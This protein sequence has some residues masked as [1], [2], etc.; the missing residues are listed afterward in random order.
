MAKD[1]WIQRAERNGGEEGAAFDGDS[2]RTVLFGR[3]AHQLR[4]DV[5]EHGKLRVVDGEPDVVICYGGDGT[6]LAA[7]I[8]WP[9]IP[10]VPILNSRRGHRC[11]PHPADEVIARL[12]E[13]SLVRNEYLKLCGRIYRQDAKT[14]ELSL[15]ALN[16][17]N[18]HMGRI[19]SAVRF[20]LWMDDLPYENELEIL[21]DGFVVSTPFGSTAYFNQITR[22]LFTQGIGVAFKY[23]SEHIDHMV[24]SE[25]VKLRFLITRGPAMLAYDSADDFHRLN[26]GDVLEV[27]RN[28]KPATIL[29]C[30]R[31]Q[32]LNE[33]F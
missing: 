22:G 32:R 21:G 7:E 18:V 23:T 31:V 6:L 15:S 20:M 33:P 11:I 24:L 30:G 3:E 1:W 29:A 28:A 17:F 8:K 19:N 4:G 9:G 12:A 27:Q 5:A 2:L 10:K 13:G 16:E 26:E 14:A 25:A